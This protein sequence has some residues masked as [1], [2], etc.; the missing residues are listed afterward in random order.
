MLILLVFEKLLN[1]IYRASGKINN[2]V[3]GTSAAGSVRMHAMQPDQLDA[4]AKALQG[5]V[6]A[7]FELQ[8]EVPTPGLDL[9]KDNP[10]FSVDFGRL[11]ICYTDQATGQYKEVSVLE[12]MKT[13]SPEGKALNDA[14][15]ALAVQARG[16]VG[17]KQIHPE[18]LIQQCDRNFNKSSS[19]RKPDSEFHSRLPRSISEAKPAILS[20]RPEAVK[21]VEAAE[22]RL[23]A[24][25]VALTGQIQKKESEIGAKQ[26]EI[27]GKEDEIRSADP[28]AKEAKQ[29]ELKTLQE[30]LAPLNRGLEGLKALQ[31]KVDG[32]DEF[33]LTL[34][35]AYSPGP[36][37]TTQDIDKAAKELKQATEEIYNQGY[38]EYY[39]EYQKPHYS[40]YKSKPYSMGFGG[41]SAPPGILGHAYQ[42]IRDIPMVLADGFGSWVGFQR[43]PPDRP[44]DSQAQNGVQYAGDV[45]ALLYNQIKDPS[46]ERLRY[47]TYCQEVGIQVAKQHATDDIFRALIAA[48]ADPK[49]LL[50]KLDKEGALDVADRTAIERQMNSPLPASR[51][52]SRGTP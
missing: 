35:L 41:E 20:R 21:K 28:A 39:K 18:S 11:V 33:A 52:G 16:V 5:V 38:S 8:E 12:A 3:M 40:W 6:N 37:A 9:A 7:L 44:L 4:G 51:P 32:I 24:F 36:D 46:E 49:Q 29:T 15:E 23:T 45:G 25:K 43:V 19:L 14:M 27:T 26:E 47:A 22:K 34:A 2:F 42:A 48:E 10:K 31:E 17:S 30:Q 50:A 1:K 13:P